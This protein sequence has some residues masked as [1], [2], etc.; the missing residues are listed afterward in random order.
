MT[1]EQRY[2]LDLVD[3]LAIRLDCAK[4]GSAAAISPAAWKVV[5]DRCPGCGASLSTPP[6]G[7]MTPLQR[8][9]EGLKGLLEQMNATE[10]KLPYRVRLEAPSDDGRKSLGPEIQAP[11]GQKGPAPGSEME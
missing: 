5:P 6:V 3:V 10:G 4:C 2:V 8:F 7:G 11:G 9:A 1:T